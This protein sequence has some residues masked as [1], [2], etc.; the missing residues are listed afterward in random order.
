MSKRPDLSTV[1]N[2]LNSETVIN[3]N[4]EKIEEAFDNTLSR[5]GST[6][7]Q[8][9]ADLDLNSNNVI[10]A[11]D[12]Q[13]NKITV[14]GVT[15]VPNDAVS[16]P[17]WKGAWATTTAYIVNDLVREDG[18]S[19]ICI[20]AH[21]SG[22][23]S[24]DLT[25]NK[26]ELF[27]QKGTAGAGTGDML[28]AN[29]LSD[30][31][32]APTSRSNLGLG[33]LAV[34]STIDTTDVDAGDKTGS[35]TDFVTGTA[36]TDGDLV[37]WNADG[38]VVDG[39]SYG[40]AANNLLQ[41]NSSA[42]APASVVKSTLGPTD[43]TSAS[44]HDYTIPSWVTK[45]E[46][47]MS[48]M[49][50]NSGTDNFLVQLSTGGTFKTSGYEAYS[51]Q[52]GTTAASASGF[53]LRQNN[54]SDV[55]DGVMTIYKMPGS[56]VWISKHILKTQLGSGYVDLAGTIDEL[57]FKIEAGKTFDNGTLGINLYP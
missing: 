10:N 40:T 28:A 49:S 20:E 43:L 53:V 54:A 13:T 51:E 39:P 36:G 6:P 23:F 37:E 35:D 26:W 57:R 21:T 29:N 31:A 3:E 33:S 4:N 38:D 55:W 56:D 41:L 1:S 30:V 42:M 22:T 9:E 19:Y 25:A 8:M 47:V 44:Q 18:N 11:N 5:D 32:D 46:L 15:L 7:N 24:T 17:S 12:V 16:V 52:G 34:K 27:A 45:I 50:I 14:A 48:R 2:I